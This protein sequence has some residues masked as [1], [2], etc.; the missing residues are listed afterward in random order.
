[1]YVTSTDKKTHHILIVCVCVCTLYIR[2]Y[3]ILQ[4]YIQVQY[5]HITMHIIRAGQWACSNLFGPPTTT[6]FVDLCAKFG[7]IYGH[8]LYWRFDAKISGML[9]CLLVG[10]TFCYCF[11]VPECSIMHLT[12]SAFFLIRFALQCRFYLQVHNIS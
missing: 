3:C 6:H 1:M 8:Q 12:V 7:K 10:R 2:T 4:L 9:F 11:Y 5:I